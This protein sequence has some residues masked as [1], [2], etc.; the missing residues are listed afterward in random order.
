[1]HSAPDKTATGRPGGSNQRRQV[2]TVNNGEQPLE[3]L[4]T[5]TT[6]GG[7]LAL[8]VA[9]IVIVTSTQQIANAFGVQP[10]V[11]GLFLTAPMTALPAAFTTWAVVRSGQVTSGV[12]SPIGD[13]TVAL[14]LGALPLAIVALPVQNYPL[15]LVILGFVA[16]MPAAYAALVHTN[17]Q[18]HGLSGPRVGV[19]LG[20]L[21][22]Y[23]GAA[24]G[25]LIAT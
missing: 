4:A 5:L 21:V 24:G 2:R 8:G 17:R 13:N 11:A 14:T 7:L 9:S 23:V 3:L 6:L 19:L 1:M 18:A 12:T 22:L 15:Y 25:V 10:L 16:L 20:L